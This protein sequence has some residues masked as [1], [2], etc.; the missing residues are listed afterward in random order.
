VNEQASRIR[1]LWPDIFGMARGKYVPRA[2]LDHSPHFCISTYAVAHDL[3][4][5]PIE[6]YAGDVGYPD[7]VGH[8]DRN[9]LRPGWEP[10]TAVGMLD[11]V[12]EDGSPV[13]IDPR[14][15]LIEAIDSWKERGLNPV[16]G[17]EMEFFLLEPDGDSWKPLSTPAHRIY[18][19]GG[20]SDPS[21]VTDAIYQAALDCEL[22]IDAITSE[23][24]PAQIEVNLHHADALEATD[25]A[26]LFRN[27]AHEIAAQRGIGVTFMGRPFADRG[28]NGLHV[29]MSFFDEDGANVLADPTDSRGISDLARQ[30]VAGQIEH[31]EALAAICAPTVNAYKRLL[32]GMINGF[33]AN[34]GFDNRMVA[35][36]V[37]GAR[38]PATRLENRVADGAMNP[39][40]AAAAMLRACLLGVDDELEPPDPQSGDVDTEPNTDRTVPR[41]L[42]AALE[43]LENDKALTDALG[44]PIVGAFLALKKAE[45]ERFI[46]AVTDWELKE[47]LAIY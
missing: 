22:P 33:Y 46:T 35:V 7:M 15:V 43:A 32:P 34:W 17:Y 26:F 30:C 11:M 29:N 31:F 8:L 16:L 25:V 24:F 21:G 39:Y 1:L 3:D 47:Y 28:G 37:P 19:T 5:V 36:R 27:L 40:L 4:I 14:R 12:Y 13:A 45:W 2:H 23:Y 10:D 42:G 38:G 20:V 6:G 18:G 9:S 41:T 44:A